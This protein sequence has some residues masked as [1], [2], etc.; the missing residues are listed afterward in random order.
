MIVVVQRVKFAKVE[1]G[2]ELISQISQG[3]VTLLG[4]KKGDSEA[5]L[6]RVLRKIASLRIFPDSQGKMNLSLKDVGGEHLIISQFT[7]LANTEKGNRPSFLDAEVPEKAQVIYELALEKSKNL[8]LTTKGGKFG[9]DMKV[10]LL[11]DGPVTI[12]I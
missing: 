11:N 3:L 10:T 8:G 4:V 12:V 2:G 7:L 9:A 5:E 1:V 6:D